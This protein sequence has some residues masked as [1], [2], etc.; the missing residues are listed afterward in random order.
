[1]NRTGCDY[2]AIGTKRP[3]GKWCGN[4]IHRPGKIGKG[5]QVRRL[6]TSLKIEGF[7]AGAAENQMNFDPGP[8]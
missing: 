1:M 6:F 3:T 7:L 4:V 8:A 2:H 5:L